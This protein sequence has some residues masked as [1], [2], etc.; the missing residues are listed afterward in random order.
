MF[1]DSFY[2]AAGF[3][4]SV[5]MSVEIEKKYRLT[6]EWRVRIEDELKELGAEF[7]G[8]DFEENTIYGGEVLARSASVVRIRRTETRSVLT[9][10]HRI[11]DV[12]DAKH[13]IEYESDIS[14]AESVAKILHELELE[15]KIV[16]EKRRSTWK[17]RSVEVVL[18][19]LPFGLFM[20]IEG[21][22]TAIDEAESLLG[23]NELETEHETY[24]RLT[25]RLGKR[26]GNIVEARFT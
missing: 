11:E 1:G 14:D 16:Y 8:E 19:E 6:R 7:V 5:E 4:C 15:P 25:T 24:P 17:L 12:S 10:K 9:F 2:L 26:N 21:S 22:L 23:I 13:Q 20:E 18:D 3:L